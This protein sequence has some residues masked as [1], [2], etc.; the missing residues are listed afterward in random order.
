MN[1]RTRQDRGDMSMSR[2]RA[3][4]QQQQQQQQMTRQRGQQGNMQQQG[5]QPYSF[6]R[7]GV[8]YDPWGQPQGVYYEEWT[9]SGPFTGMGPDGY[10]R[11]DERIMEDVC[12]RLTQHGR[13]DARDVHVDVKD[14]EVTLT[15][16]V[17]SRQEK[18]MAEDTVESVAGVEDVHN[19]L[20]IDR[21]D[22]QEHQRQMQQQKQGQQQQQG[23]ARKSGM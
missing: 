18:R 17:H 13:L 15:G 21:H 8:L 3:Q 4:Q 10:Q 19:D 14:G 9:V 23:Q 20:R 12:D 22:E 7:Q 5:D 6:A 11:S 1:D 2:D 16:H